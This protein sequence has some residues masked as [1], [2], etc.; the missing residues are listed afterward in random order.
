M[1][2]SR[3]VAS[4]S[5]VLRG[6]C[7]A[8]GLPVL[9]ASCDGESTVPVG[10]ADGRSACA[11]EDTSPSF[12]SPSS[13]PSLLP[14]ASLSFGVP[15]PSASFW[16]STDAAVWSLFVSASSS[17]LLPAERCD[18]GVSDLGAAGGGPMGLPSGPSATAPGGNPRYI[19]W[20]APGC[21]YG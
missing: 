5:A 7:D 15:S 17:C 18:E 8:E 6:L 14:S 3:A 21:G 13:V 2:A 10:L 12:F 1:Y 20:G 11:E 9:P 4:V 16:T 19:P